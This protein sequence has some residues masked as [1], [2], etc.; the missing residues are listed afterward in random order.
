MVI[1]RKSATIGSAEKVT[2][3]VY[4]VSIKLASYTCELTVHCQV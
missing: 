1:D 2:A 4:N 3:P